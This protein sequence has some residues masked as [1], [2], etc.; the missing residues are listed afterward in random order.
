MPNYEHIEYGY[1]L[2]IPIDNFKCYGPYKR[3]GMK[4]YRNYNRNLKSKGAISSTDLYLIK[5]EEANVKV[6]DELKRDI[7]FDGGRLIRRPI[8]A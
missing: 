8:N 2:A 6:I 1:G 5:L 3:N 4:K 7:S